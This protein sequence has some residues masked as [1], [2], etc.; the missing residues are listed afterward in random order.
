MLRILV[1]LAT[2]VTVFACGVGIALLTARARRHQADVA[3]RIAAVHELFV[4]ETADRRQ[5]RLRAIAADPAA[6][7][8][9]RAR[10][11]TPLTA[12]QPAVYA[13]PAPSLLTATLAEATAMLATARAQR[14]QER[15]QFADLMATL[16]GPARIRSHAVGRQYA[17]VRT[18]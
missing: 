7:G 12:V 14:V 2:H 10:P 3:E 16:I 13:P 15:R 11:V 4:S 6:A 1:L 17:D 8:R 18:A 9:H 5:R